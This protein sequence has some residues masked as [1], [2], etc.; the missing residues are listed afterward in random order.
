MSSQ[1]G[2]TCSWNHKLQSATPN[3]LPSINA[4]IPRA[5]PA[6]GLRSA[7]V[8]ASEA[9]NMP[10]PAPSFDYYAELEVSRSA[11][12][13]EITAAYRRLARVHHPDKNP[14][15]QDA[16]TAKFQRVSSTFTR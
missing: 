8:R 4:Q 1:V 11:P 13:Q 14:E 7:L 2:R 3:G 6:I 16:A 9:D 12:L 15:M 10:P 5:A